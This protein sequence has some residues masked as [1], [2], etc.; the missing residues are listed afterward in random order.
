MPA[1]HASANVHKYQIDLYPPFPSSPPKRS[2]RDNE[3]HQRKVQALEKKRLQE[4][5]QGQTKGE[6]A[7]ALLLRRRQL[8]A[9]RGLRI[10]KE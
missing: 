1:L 4:L 9:K 10:S 2:Q 3:M 8:L 6:N 7:K 5:E